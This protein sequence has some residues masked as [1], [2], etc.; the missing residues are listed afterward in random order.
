MMPRP[1]GAKVLRDLKIGRH[2]S[3]TIYVDTEVN[4]RT[5][6]A[7]WAEIV[8]QIYARMLGDYIVNV[9]GRVIS[10]AIKQCKREG[11]KPR[12]IGKSKRIDC[13]DCVWN[14]RYLQVLKKTSFNVRDTVIDHVGTLVGTVTG[15]VSLCEQLRVKADARR[16][17]G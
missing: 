12:P 13:I 5:G 1:V 9:L 14:S 2:M 11:L 7:A 16:R 8:E 3:E 4:L 17:P 10:Q 15:A 6:G